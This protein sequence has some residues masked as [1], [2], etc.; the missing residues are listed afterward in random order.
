MMSLRHLP[1][2]RIMY[3]LTRAMRRAMAPLARIDRALASSGVNP[4]WGPMR[5]V[6]VR[7]AAVISTLRTVDHLVPLKTAAMCVSGVD[8]CCHRCATRLRMSGTAHARGCH[9]VPCQIDS[10]LMPFFFVVKRRLTKV[11]AE[12]VAAEAVVA[13]VG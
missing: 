3:V 4:T 11:V 1:T 6:A 2:K 10:P 5:V 12:Q 7:S 13:W 9:V 8:P